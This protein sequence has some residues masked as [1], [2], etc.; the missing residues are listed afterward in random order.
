M[1]TAE[2]AFGLLLRRSVNYLTHNQDGEE[3][4]VSHRN[5]LKGFPIDKCHKVRFITGDHRGN[6]WIATTV[7]ALRVN[8]DF[9]NPEDAVFHHYQRIQDDMYSLSNNDVHWILSTGEKEL[10]LPPLAAG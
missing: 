6:I 4:F 9:K 8:G 1:R 10:Y 7:G 3:I 2:G 5:N